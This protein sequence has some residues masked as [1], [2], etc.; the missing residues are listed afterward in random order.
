[1]SGSGRSNLSKNER[2]ISQNFFGQYDPMKERDW[3]RSQN[4]IREQFD[5]TPTSTTHTRGGQTT[6][7]IDKRGDKVGRMVLMFDRAIVTNGLPA[8]WEGAT[9]IDVIRFKYQ[10]KMFHEI[11]GEELVDKIKLE[12]TRE[13]RSNAAPLCNGLLSPSEKATSAAQAQTI[14]V[15]LMVPWT[16]L[17]R[18][19]R[20]V[21]LPNYIVVEITWQT[22]SKVFVNN[23][24][25]PSGG[26]ISN[27]YLRTDFHHLKNTKRQ[28]LF[29]EVHT[30][31]LNL[32]Y[33][34]KEYHRR[35]PL[36]TNA[37]TGTI[38]WS[39]KL[40][41]IKNDSACLVAY[42]RPQTAVDNGS[43]TALDPYTHSSYANLTY[44]LQD[45]GVA[46]TNQFV[47]APYSEYSEKY[48]TFPNMYHGSGQNYVVLPFTID[49]RLMKH[50]QFDCYGSRCI[51]KYN[52]P[53]FWISLTGPVAADQYVDVW[54]YTHNC[55]IQYKGDIRRF[56]L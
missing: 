13:E 14:W 4:T 40:R 35:E 7:N 6:I 27:V 22:L 49:P 5:I 12:M 51:S 19:L 8:D 47:Q 10:N 44:W 56:L 23:G 55:I 36:L 18:M 11:Y 15:D 30:S 20:M 45:N 52:N 41:N 37:S 42:I 38:T 2:G 25:T 17:E 50:S 24:G 53:E 43:G 34:S 3:V 16:D 26:T 29:N 21:A 9:S 28:Q 31:P 39:V 33:L 32:K 1:M 54:S 46:V 48:L